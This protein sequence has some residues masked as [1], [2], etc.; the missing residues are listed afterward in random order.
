VLDACLQI[1]GEEGSSLDFRE[2]ARSTGVRKKSTWPLSA[3]RSGPV[4]KSVLFPACALKLFFEKI[5]LI[6]IH[7]KYIF[8]NILKV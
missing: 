2:C 5:F 6:N 1:Y 3:R 4:L 7:L 8:N